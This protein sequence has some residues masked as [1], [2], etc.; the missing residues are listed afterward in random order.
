MVRISV[1]QRRA[2]LLSIEAACDWS[3]RGLFLTAL[4]SSIRGAGWIGFLIS[5]SATALGDSV[6]GVYIAEKRVAVRDQGGLEGGLGLGVVCHAHVFVGHF[7]RQF[8]GLLEERLLGELAAVFA[9]DTS[10]G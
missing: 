6:P 2:L 7:L 4:N 1:F 9:V 10:H 8:V 3:V 5:S